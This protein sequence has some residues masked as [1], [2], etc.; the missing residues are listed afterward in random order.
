MSPSA[1]RRTRSA[2]RPTPL[3]IRFRPSVKRIRNYEAPEEGREGK[4]RLDFNENTIGCSPAV[5]RA[6]RKITPEQ[7]AMYPEYE[8]SLRRLAAY[9]GVRPSEMLLTNGVDDALRL[10]M[11]NWGNQFSSSIPLSFMPEL[12]P[13]MLLR[14][15]DTFNI[16]FYV[17]SVMHTFDFSETGGGFSTN[18]TVTAPSKVNADKPGL[19]GVALGGP[20]P[21][22]TAAGGG[23]AGPAT[24][25]G[26]R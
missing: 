25:V 7:L 6:L 23:T 8:N 12:F 17:K 20:P 5:M 4:L 13:G 1:P 2:S 19:Y 16:Q 9:F 11:E 26:Q 10:F 24:P 3:E 18:V 21:G 15:S 14:L 22:T